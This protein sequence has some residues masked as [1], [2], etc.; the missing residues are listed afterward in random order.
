[1]R[2]APTS[3]LLLLLLGPATADASPI[4]INGSFEQGP[5]PFTSHDI[6]IPAGSTDVTGWTILAGG[7][8]LL[9]DPWDV[10]DGERAIDLDFRSPG[11]IE[12]A[13]GTAP[14]RKYVLSFDL[15]GNPEGGS[16]LKRAQVAVGDALQDYS[17]DSTGQTLD[18]LLW[19]TVMLSFM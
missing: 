13:L 6:G 7:V 2:Y 17:F 15:S 14:G 1:M 12:Q 5:P 4:L 19:Q 11:G 18:A 3:L 16:L 10:S 8:D 9:E